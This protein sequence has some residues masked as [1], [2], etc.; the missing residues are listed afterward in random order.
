MVVGRPSTM[1][2]WT[3]AESVSVCVKEGN[4]VVC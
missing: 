2:T 4:D 3:P 1:G